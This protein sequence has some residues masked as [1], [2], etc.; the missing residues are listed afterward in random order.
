METNTQE[1]FEKVS[2]ETVPQF[3]LKGGTT[4]IIA[5]EMTLVN[6][7]SQENNA[8]LTEAGLQETF[9]NLVNTSNTKSP[10]T[11]KTE[12]KEDQS[13]TEGIVTK[14]NTKVEEWRT[15]TSEARALSKLEQIAAAL[16]LDRKAK[17]STSQSN[18]NMRAD[19]GITLESSLERI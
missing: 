1:T 6:R 5:T 2:E 13:T 10:G 14:N 3:E 15:L 4:E 9:A 12:Y 8:G 19:K 18:E 16:H 11:E 7:N 17:T